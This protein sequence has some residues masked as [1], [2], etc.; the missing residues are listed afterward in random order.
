MLMNDNAKPRYDART[1]IAKL[2]AITAALEIKDP[3]T[4]GHAR[5]VAVYARRLAER[6]G[7]NAVEAEKIRL[8]GLLHD[9]GKIGLSEQLLNNTRN[10]LSADMPKAVIDFVHFHHEKMD[11]SGY[12]HGLRSYQIPLGAKIIRVVDCF[13]AITTDRPYQQ[14]KS[15]IEAFAILLQISGTDLNAELVEAFTADIKENGLA[16]YQDRSILLYS[17]VFDSRF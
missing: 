11:G 16:L 13:D 9:I 10:R 12:P 4:R 15:W 6:I 8:G 1:Q 7:L 5:R 17:P 2:T 14:R 3:Y